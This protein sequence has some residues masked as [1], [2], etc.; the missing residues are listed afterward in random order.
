MR[1]FIQQAIKHPGIFTKQ[2]K[3]AHMSVQAYAREHMHD[4][5]VTGKRARLAITLNRLAKR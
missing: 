2:A 1:N 5:G 4:S 3:R